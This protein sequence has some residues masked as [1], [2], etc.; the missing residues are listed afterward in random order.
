MEEVVEKT[1]SSR[2]NKNSKNPA[3]IAAIVVAGVVVV[4]GLGYTGLCFATGGNDILYPN[5]I[6]D[7][8]D[9]GG[10]TSTEAN[11]L[12][13]ETLT[14]RLSTMEV[15]FSCEGNQYAVAGSL[16]TVNPDQPIAAALEEQ[17]TQFFAKGAQY[18]SALCQQRSYDGTVTLDEPP[19]ILTQ[20]AKESVGEDAYATWAV[21][22]DTL[23]IQKGVTSNSINQEALM[24]LLEGEANTLLQDGV[25]GGV[26]APVDQVSSI[27]PD[28]DAIRNGIYVEPQDAYLDGDTKEVVDAVTGVDID[29][30]G[31]VAQ[32]TEVPEGETLSVSLVY[33]YP[34][35]SNETYETLLFAD[36]LG[37]TQT[38]CSGPTARWYNIDLVASF[39]DGTIL[40][41]GE[42]FSYTELC[43]PY[44]ASNGYKNAG[45]YVD[46]MSVDA[47]AG[48]ICQLSST[49][50]WATLEANLETV[51]RTKHT[52][53]TG[54]M[55]ILGTDATVYGD[56][57]DFQFKNDTD[58][59][60][61]IETWRDTSTNVLTVNI[62]GTNTTGIHGEPYSVTVSTVTPQTVYEAKDDQPIGTTTPDSER[63]AYTGYVVDL[64]LNLVDD[65]GNVVET[66]YLY[67]NT[68]NSRNKVI[69]YNPADAQSLGIDTA[70]GTLIPV[71]EIP[72]EET[73]VEEV[74]TEE[75]VEETPVEEPTVEEPVTEEPAV[76]VTPEVV[77]E[78]ETTPEE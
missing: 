32:W 36:L 49:L 72:V 62:Y 18:L 61:K 64:Y 6:I 5:T 75:P 46:G 30:D 3:K 56:V 10:L 38:T 2:L 69:F 12:I 50:Y 39:V 66:K 17:S 33:T 74:P 35:I 43:G 51:E 44:D 54:Y 9:V 15:G 76:E 22:G 14:N 28:F 11:S 8:V 26:I 47:M 60:I 63:T 53:N 42:V 45:A 19:E 59:P 58:Y 20:A 67:R 71:E 27:D 70:T 21:E 41:P 29:L 7:G 24:E 52:Y 40:L 37:S 57:L 23:S 65:D 31:T 68:Y 25:S 4:A 13:T 34:E 16:F 1:A 77:E 78:L 73:P 55:P 48:G